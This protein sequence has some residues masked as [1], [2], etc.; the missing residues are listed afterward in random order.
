P[1]LPS[2]SAP[3]GADEAANQEIKRWGEPPRFSFEPRDHVDLA[4]GLGLL[5]LE[6]ATKISGARFSILT[7]AGARLERA[8]INFCL[9]LHTKRHRY[10]E[11]APPLIVNTQTLFGTG[12]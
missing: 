4:T 6:R 1:N 7:G 8:L 5:D 9:D 2:D 11:I 3:V 10:T 12:Q